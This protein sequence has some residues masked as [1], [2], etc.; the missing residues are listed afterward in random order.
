MNNMTIIL[1]FL[2]EY[3]AWIE[4]GV[5]DNGCF[6]AAHGLCRNLDNYALRSNPSI[7]GNRLISLGDSLCHL[8]EADNLSMI[9]PFNMPMHGQP[10]YMHE[11]H[12]EN[13]WRMKWV[14]DT[15]I[16]L[17]AKLNES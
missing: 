17:E 13:P 3:K 10:R 4:A 15:I 5:P 9:L 8:F 14:A 6:D 7:T 12:H 16:K 11:V 2:K 1:T